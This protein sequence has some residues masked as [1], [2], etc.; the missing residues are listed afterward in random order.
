M[1][2]DDRQLLG[3]VLGAKT[4]TERY[5]R[6]VKLMQ[7]GFAANMQPKPEDG[8][9]FLNNELGKTPF[10]MESAVCTNGIANGRG[11]I[12]TEGNLP[13]WGILLGVYKSRNEALKM[14]RNTR[15]RV[16]KVVKRSRIAILPRR[17]ERGTSWKTLLVGL[18]PEEAGQ[19]CWRLW[20][21]KHSCSSMSPSMLNQPGFAKR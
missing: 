16:K 5:N 12:E 1:K 13:G 15:A 3:V 10:S 4:G 18:T 8:I 2:R 19:A 7:R 20:R 21:E 9:G 6:M 14:A 11:I 17:F